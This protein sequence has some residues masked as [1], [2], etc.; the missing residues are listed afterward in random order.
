MRIESRA[1][2]KL[3]E[4]STRAV[5]TTEAGLLAAEHAA[6]MLE[7]ANAATLSLEAMREAPS[8][9]VR[10]TAPVIFGQAMLGLV[11]SKFLRRFPGCSLDVDLS[12]RQVDLIDETFDVAVRV[13]P[14]S[15]NLLIAR[16]V[17]D[18][19]AGLYRAAGCGEIGEPEALAGLPL[20][21]LHP[22][23]A[24]KPF[25]DLTSTARETRRIAVTA[26][27]VCM[28]PWLLLDVA[29]KTDIVVVLPCMVAAEDV[30]QGRLVRVVPG[31]Y[32]R[33]VPVRLVYTSRRFVRPAVRAF[34]DI[35][36]PAIQARLTLDGNDDAP[37]N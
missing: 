16:Q 27:L 11:A 12:D 24:A 13:G 10:L 37:H 29:R 36:I 1:G 33:L 23:N 31:W 28:N 32:A 2:V 5:R 9:L 6:R 15:D 34:V 26:K 22:G 21:L 3:F 35:A 19:S 30:R 18:A 4:R 17:G 25:L 8:G 14:V 20:G 7:E